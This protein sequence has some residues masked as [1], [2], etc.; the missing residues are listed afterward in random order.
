MALIASGLCWA[1]L[2][3]DVDAAASPAQSPDAATAP[4]EG[5]SRRAR[6]PQPLTGSNLL[7]P[8]LS[9]TPKQSTTDGAAGRDRVYALTPLPDSGYRYE[10]ARFEAAIAPDGQ[11]T[12]KDRHVLLEHVQVGPLTLGKGAGGRWSVESWLPDAKNRPRQSEDDLQ[13]YHALSRPEDSRASRGLPPAP[14]LIS[15]TVRFDLVDEFLRLIG[16]GSPYRHERAQFLAAT[17]ELRMGMAADNETRLEGRAISELPARLDALWSAPGYT[18][19]EK[20]RVVFLLWSEIDTSDPGGAAGAAAVLGWIRR[21]LP[22]GE[23]GAYS[24][25]ELSALNAEGRRRAD[26]P[27]APYPPGGEAGGRAPTAP[28]AVGGR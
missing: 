19:R 23:P 15:A 21:R 5:P 26:A 2:V 9:G 27:F 12:F 14:I 6:A 18:P 20:R 24:A 10:D 4:A 25:A 1:A 8:T 11:V 22:P 7:A 13:R 3:G 28:G 17:S 16:Q